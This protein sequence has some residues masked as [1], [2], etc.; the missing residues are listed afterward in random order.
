MRSLG[1][2]PIVLAVALSVGG[3]ATAPAPVVDA[4]PVD[5]SWPIALT[6]YRT[7]SADIYLG[8]LD[9]SIAEMQR[10]LA[11]RDEPEYRTALAGSLYHRYRIVGR[12]EDAEEALRLLDAAVA[13]EPK[14]ARHRQ[15]RA[16][17]LSAFHRF[18][19]A[20]ADL[21]AA[22]ESGV[23]A[24]D[25]RSTRR[26]IQLA[27]G[28]YD[29]LR[30]EFARSHELVHDFAELAHRADLRVAQGDLAGA[31]FMYRA[32]QAEYREVN[33]FPL[34]WLHLQQG[35]AYLR[36]GEVENARRFFA[37]AHERMPT[38]Y[39][40]TEHLAETETLLGNYERAREL[41]LGVIEQ[42]GNPEFTAALS[43]LERKAGNRNRAEQ[44]QK[45]AEAGYTDL[46]RRNPSA[47]AQ[48]AAEFFIDIGKPE[49]ADELAKQN[50]AIRQDIGSWILRATT[51][52]AAGDK[53]AAC[54][55]KANALA[56]GLKPLELREL[57]ALRLRCE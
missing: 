33:P 4:A 43:Q 16:V 41:Y 20:L 39:L 6:A 14:Q 51:A 42:T 55:A 12:V 1:F 19:E 32:A 9:A 53:P 13:A 10:A 11:E 8:N 40:A 38:Y 52:H 17:V 15:L 26:E 34:A 2:F 7:T 18:P 56:T 25:L 35:I 37:A 28:E 47:Y 44:L 24:A 29:K 21:D 5:P 50:L 49:R 31:T 23:R 45:E 30:E 3:C 48:H 54:A 46:L 57:E 36:F 27:L 22:E